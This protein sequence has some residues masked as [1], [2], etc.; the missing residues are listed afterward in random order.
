MTRLWLAS[1]AAFALLLST[2]DAQLTNVPDIEGLADCWG[3]EGHPY[4][5]NTVCPN[6]R[7]CCNGKATCTSNRLCHNDGDPEDV[8]I[9]GSCYDW[10]EENGWNMDTC[11]QICLGYSMNLTAAL[12][13]PPDRASSWLQSGER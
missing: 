1:L 4:P 10:D 2:C 7:T 11:A 6:S 13:E 3:F 5:N 8:W 12:Y 9:R